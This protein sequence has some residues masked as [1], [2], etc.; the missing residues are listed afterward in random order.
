MQTESEKF[1]K[2]EIDTA[3]EAVKVWRKNF[4]LNIGL[5][6]EKNTKEDVDLANK[7]IREELDEYLEAVSNDDK[8]GQVDALV[9]LFFVIVQKEC[10]DFWFA[11]TRMEEYEYEPNISTVVEELLRHPQHKSRYFDCY[12]TIAK[13]LGSGF[14]SAVDEVFKSNMSKACVT[15]EEAQQTVAKYKAEGVDTYVK[16]Y[17]D[18]F[19]VK[20]KNDGKVLK[21]INFKEPDLKKFSWGLE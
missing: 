14:L 11:D 5:Y 1:K 2:S 20:R 16:K 18:Y 9:D 7:L 13:K 4:G 17:N 19:V 21:S 6:G 3:K 10:V 15:E 12:K 8:V